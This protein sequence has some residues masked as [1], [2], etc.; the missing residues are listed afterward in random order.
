MNYE[1]N[2]YHGMALCRIVHDDRVKSIKL[3]PTKS[4]SSYMINEDIGVFLKYSTKRMTP[5]RFTFMRE[6]REEICEMCEIL[7]AVF[8]VLR[9][10]LMFQPR[11]VFCETSES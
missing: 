11:E 6:H 4:N 1:F 5:W 2:F 10:R 7:K 8:V 9:V 3:Y